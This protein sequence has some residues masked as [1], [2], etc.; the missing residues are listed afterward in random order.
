MSSTSS[1]PFHLPAITECYD[2][3]SNSA[4]YSTDILY[5]S[6][7]SYQYILFLLCAISVYCK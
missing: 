2:E 4:E 6:Y 1:V 5:I 7:A 3:R